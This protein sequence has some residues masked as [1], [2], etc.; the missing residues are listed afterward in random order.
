MIIQISLPADG[1]QTLHV[2][3]SLFQA[4]LLLQSYSPF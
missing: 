1:G 4:T 3:M 2:T